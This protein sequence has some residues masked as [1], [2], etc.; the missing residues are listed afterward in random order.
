LQD[1]I[2]QGG[3]FQNEV[4]ECGVL[5]DEVSQRAIDFSL[6]GRLEPFGKL[7]SI[8]LN[9]PNPTSKLIH[10]IPFVVLLFEFF[11]IAT[12]IMVK[13]AHRPQPLAKRLTWYE[14]RGT[15]LPGPA[16]KNQSI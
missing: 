4:C 8:G 5:Q 13:V 15:P 6:P 12:S 3:I 2:D 1:E 14:T 10:S 9:C 16:C 11:D 7:D